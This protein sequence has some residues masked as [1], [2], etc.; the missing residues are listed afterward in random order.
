V[1]LESDSSGDQHGVFLMFHRSAC[2][3]T[4][5]LS[6]LGKR[7]HHALLI[8]VFL[9]QEIFADIAAIMDIVKEFAENSSEDTLVYGLAVKVRI[10]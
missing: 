3:S 5:V 9:L 8:H 2:V 6:N 4:P 10:L 1:V 7:S